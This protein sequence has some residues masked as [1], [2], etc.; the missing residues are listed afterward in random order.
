VLAQNRVLAKQLS[1]GL[2]P[3][4]AHS[5]VNHFRQQGMIWAFDAK[6]EDPQLAA[7]F[8][9]R[10]FASA[11]KHELLLRPIGTTVYLMPPYILSDSET[12]FLAERLQTVFSEV[13]GA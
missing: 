6:V 10:F 3:L 5:K 1:D 7:T 8:S 13:I 2:A 9:R 11:L 12:G 4:A